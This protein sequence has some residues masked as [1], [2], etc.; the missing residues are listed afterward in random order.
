MECPTC[1]SASPDV[2]AYCFRCGTRLRTRGGRRNDAYAVQSSESVTQFAIVSTIMPHTSR[3]SGDTYRWALLVSALVVGVLTLTGLLPAAVLAAAFA[4]P[5]IYLIYIYDVN[6][7]EDQPVPVLGAL[8]VGTGILSTLLSLVFF[9]W[10]FDRQFFILTTASG[11][12]LGGEAIPIGPLLLFAA[13]LPILAIVA[14]NLGPVRLAS[15]PEFDDMIDGL[16]FGIAAGTAY[17]AAETIVAFLPVF[18][19]GFRTTEG[20]LGWI[21]VIL[22]L[23]IVKSLIYGTATGIAVATFS[24]LGE[25]HDG[26]TPKYFANLAFAAGMN[27]VYWLGIRLLAYVEQGAWLGLVWGLVV[28]A[29]LVLRLR[30]L[31]HAALLEAAVEDAVG[32]R[33]A[34]AAVTGGGF[35][36]QCEMPL[37]PDALFCI[38][39]GQSVRATSVGDRRMLRSNGGSV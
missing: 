39:C 19:I 11:D 15:R 33:R 13:V 29:I 17:A 36:P 24:G 16:T 31:L 26:F 21:P 12:R 20:V 32:K 30:V 38:T 2:A 27:V 4:V 34:K 14:M 25:G 1:R 37:L 35:C 28:L 6:L 5:I 7:W 23:M 10:A 18:S 3:R 8:F 9:R 22:N